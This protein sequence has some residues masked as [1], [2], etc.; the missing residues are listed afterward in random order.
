[1]IVTVAEIR[2]ADEII[3]GTRG[4][5]PLRGALGSVAHTLLHDAPCP[6][7]V[8]PPAAVERLQ[9]ADDTAGREVVGS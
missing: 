6:V 3:V 1:V 7:T 5:G 2:Q 8:I 4:F 9:R